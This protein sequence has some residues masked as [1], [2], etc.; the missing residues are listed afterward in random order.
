MKYISFVTMGNHSHKTKEYKQ[1]HEHSHVG[2]LGE[3]TE[4]YFAIFAGFFFFA[5]L[6]L[7]FLFT[8]DPI[9][10]KFSYLVSLIFGGYYTSIEAFTKLRKGQFEFDFLML[11]AA[12]AAVYIDQWAEASLL[13]FLFSLGHSL[14]HYA[15]NKAR[16]NILSLGDLRPKT[17]FLKQNNE[18]IEIPIEQLKV[19]DVIV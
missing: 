14:E 2:I 4:L 6:I 10:P 9:W 1:H 18:L 19:G 16:N 5:G 15:M 12:I 7:E 13:L 11:I 3:N 8:L 17:A